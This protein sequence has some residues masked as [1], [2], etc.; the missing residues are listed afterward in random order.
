MNTLYRRCVVIQL[1]AVLA[2]AQ[3]WADTTNGT[4][5]VNVTESQHVGLAD[6]LY[7][8]AGTGLESPPGED[9]TFYG[10]V[11]VNWGIPLTP[12]D[13]VALGLQLGG[14]F[15][16]RDDDPEWNL[17]FGGFGRNFR[18]FQDQQGMAAMLF[19]YRRTAFHNGVWDLRPIIGTTL[20]PQDA[21]GAEGVASLNSDDGQE[22]I[23]EFSVFWTR[24]WT[25]V[26][27]T[28]LGSGYQFSGVDEG[29]FRGRVA[30]GLT[31]HIDLACGGDFNTDGDY[32]FGVL[33]SYGFGGTGRHPALHN[34]GGSGRGLYTPL[35]DASFP[36]LEHRTR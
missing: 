24:D 19:D 36:L 20:T 15:K 21:L 17:T 23:S 31:P 35:P 11:G 32:A 14:N 26:I 22:A 7:L 9:S 27:G 5:A 30:F 3:S 18:I 1:A 4:E 29:L 8:N 10:L 2:S 33:F 25:D 34:I 6:N 28:E 12:P 13:G 16:V